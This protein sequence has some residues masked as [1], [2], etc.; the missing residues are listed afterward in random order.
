MAKRTGFFGLLLTIVLAIPATLPAQEITYDH[1][2]A[3]VIVPQTRPYTMD[4]NPQVLMEKVAVDIEVTG[5]MAVTVMSIDLVNPTSRRL[6]AELLLPVPEGAMVRSFSY[7]GERDELTAKLLPLDEASRTYHGLVAKLRDPGLLEFAGYNLIRSSVFPVEARGKQKVRVTYEQLLPA[8]GSRLDYLLP[9]SQSLECRAPWEVKLRF[10]MATPIATIY[11]PTHEVVVK[12][13]RREEAEVTVATGEIMAPGPLL[14]SCLLEKNGLTASL[15]SYPDPK[16]G[17]GYFLLLAGLDPEPSPLLKVKP[18]PREV[19]LVIDKSGS[20][21]GEKMA[22]T[23]QAALEIVSRLGEGETFNL[24][25]YNEA[26]EFFAEAP[27]VKSA[28]TL[29]Q[30]EVWIESIRARGGTNIHDALIEALRMRPTPGALPIVLFM[31]DGLPTIGTISEKAIREVAVKGNPYEKRVFTFGVGLDVNTPLLSRIAAETRAKPTF[32]LSDKDV[33]AKIGRV[34]RS[35]SGPVLSDGNL[36][37]LDSAG[38]AAPGRV[39]EVLPVRLPDLFHGDQL[40]VLGHYL[41]EE[42]L[43]FQVDGR[44]FGREKTFR[45]AFDPDKATTKNS[46]VPR[47]WASRKIGVLIDEIRQAGADGD[48]LAPARQEELVSEIVKL[49]TEFGIMTEY[50]AFLALDGTDLTRPDENI[51]RTAA[52]MR[53][54]AVRERSGM[55]AVNQELNS[56]AMAEQKVL[57]TANVYYNSRLEQVNVVNVRQ[58]ADRAFVNRNNRWIDTRVAGE[59]AATAPARVVEFGSE[60]FVKL[61]DELV[62]QNRQSVLALGGEIVMEIN[63]EVIAIRAA[64]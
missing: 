32:V 40:V 46:F 21:S 38:L 35:L 63:G 34:F 23:K 49:S 5:Q 39:R 52:T 22:Q 60:E 57:N 64:K 54:R 26:V 9:R 43:T 58:V 62:K 16:I 2:A 50:T 45:V 1:F 25:V 19:L 30:A 33:E 41:G 44:H 13:P 42:P 59:P 55:A 4:R 56:N 61:V 27:V 37:V 29:R 10:R 47:L 48:S 17:G 24:L 51:R 7:N 14:I 11:S 6:E 3:N 28:A 8:D 18:V 53:E 31:T 12:Q 15:M 20:M 36:R